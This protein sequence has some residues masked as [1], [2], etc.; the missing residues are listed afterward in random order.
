MSPPPLD[1]P[2]LQCIPVM[3]LPLHLQCQPVMLLSVHLRYIP[4]M[5]LTLSLVSEHEVQA[6]AV[7]DRIDYSSI[8]SERRD[9]E[10]DLYDILTTSA[11]GMNHC[12]DVY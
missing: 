6:F 5:L 7:K 2:A 8:T 9:G 11:I 1:F 12:N 10:W 4:A 3:M